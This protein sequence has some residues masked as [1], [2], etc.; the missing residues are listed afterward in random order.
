MNPNLKT[1]RGHGFYKKGNKLLMLVPKLL[2]FK[3]MCVIKL[4]LHTEMEFTRCGGLWEE[5]FAVINFLL[6]LVIV[7]ELQKLPHS[8][9]QRK[10]KLQ[11]T[12]N[13]ITIKYKGQ[14]IDVILSSIAIC[15]IIF[16]VL[17]S[18]KNHF[19]PTNAVHVEF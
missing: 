15:R 13:T 16:Q 4:S 6:L 11:F 8:T 10:I 7:A 1:Q 14:Q 17:H 2:V 12:E 3:K 5:R 19:H 18:T 9:Q